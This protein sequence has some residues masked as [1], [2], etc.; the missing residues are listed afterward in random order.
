AQVFRGQ[1]EGLF[2]ANKR[3]DLAYNAHYRAFRDLSEAVNLDLGF[4]YGAGPNNTSTEEKRR[5]TRLEAIDFTLRWKPLRTGT[6]R[7]A[8]S[9][10]TRHSF[11]CNSQSAPTALIPSEANV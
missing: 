4:S 5:W 11:N 7:S 6:Y 10:P 2:E 8:G 1:S 3:S 9:P